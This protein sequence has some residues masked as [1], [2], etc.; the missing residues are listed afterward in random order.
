MASRTRLPLRAALLPA[1]G[2][3][4]A[5]TSIAAHAQAPLRCLIVGGGPDKQ[6]N[7]VAIE[8]NV[9]YVQRLLPTG[10][11]KRVLFTNG[12]LTAANVQY[13]D[14]HQHERYRATTLKSID[15]PARLATFQKTFSGLSAD[16]GGPFLLYFTGHGSPDEDGTYTNNAYD[17]W[18]D[19]VLT[20]DSLS[21][22]LDN[23]D[24]SSPTVLVMAQCFSGAFADVVFRSAHTKGPSLRPNFC[25]FFAS[26]SVRPAAGCT[27][28]VNEADYHDF[29][30][31][32]FGALSGH[33]RLGHAVTGA[34]YD[35]D[36]RVGMNEA[37]A[38][39]LI[40]DPSIDTP[41]STSDAFVRRYVKTPE[42]IVF[43]TAYSDVLKWASPPQAA[44]LEALSKQ[45]G[46]HG[47]L[48]L[49]TAYRTF[50]QRTTDTPDAD[51]PEDEDELT[52]RWIRIVRLAKTIVLAHTLTT[53]PDEALKTQYAALL[54]A[55]SANPIAPKTP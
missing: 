43:H 46:L 38:Y 42:P 52:A 24:A 36:G 8:S 19:D 15:G 31:Y 49:L 22:A 9:R 14:E 27:P 25:G 37:F 54:Q 26:V 30:S 47:E 39:A 11:K 53:G 5:F 3:C 17:M 4:S 12:S 33:D 28:E 1:L 32:F 13:E 48:R 2:L 45:L 21:D 16:A 29:T 18:A 6:Y 7:Q 34:D 55:E 35:R 40:H 10:T 23:A 44:A 50:K 20:V 41:V 51:A